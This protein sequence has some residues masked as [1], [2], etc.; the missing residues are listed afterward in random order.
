MVK[1]YFDQIITEKL[2]IYCGSETQGQSTVQPFPSILL[3]YLLYEM[4]Y[5]ILINRTG[6]LPIV[7]WNAIASYYKTVWVCVN[8]S[9]N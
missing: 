7:G 8:N 2:L 9:P 4:I 3:C 6:L 1:S 5:E